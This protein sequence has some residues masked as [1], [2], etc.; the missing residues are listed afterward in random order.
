MYVHEH[1]FFLFFFF[2][3]LPMII[4]CLYLQV[5]K[6]LPERQ[7]LNNYHIQFDWAVHQYRLVIASHV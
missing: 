5:K 6:L 3:L 1:P 4:E 7:K 2:S